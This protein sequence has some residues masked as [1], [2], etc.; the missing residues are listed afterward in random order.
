MNNQSVA[1]TDP[2]SLVLNIPF[3]KA[4]FFPPVCEQCTAPSA[5]QE[6]DQVA[7]PF[8]HSSNKLWSCFGTPNHVRALWP[9]TVLTLPSAARRPI[10][11]NSPIG[12]LH[13]LDRWAGLPPRGLHP[14]F[15]PALC[16][17]VFLPFTD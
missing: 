6:E 9:L 5:Y 3:F 17:W 12:P 16:L 1:F 13:T 15:D 14:L 4:L 10:K 7:R 11:A 2:N 8:T